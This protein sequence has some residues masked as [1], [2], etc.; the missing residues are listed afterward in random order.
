MRRSLWRLFAIR[1][2]RQWKSGGPSGDVDLPPSCEKKS[3]EL[4]V[5]KDNN[6]PL[7]VVQNVSGAVKEFVCTQHY[8]D[9]VADAEKNGNNDKIS[10]PHPEKVVKAMTEA[11]TRAQTYAKNLQKITQYVQSKQI[12]VSLP[13]P[14]I[15]SLEHTVQFVLSYGAGISPSWTL[16]AIKGPSSSG[17]VLAGSFAR[18]Q[19]LRLAMG[20]AEPATPASSEQA[21]IIQNQTILLSR[22]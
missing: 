21:R 12:S 14:P 16:V 7:S 19:I 2:H 11:A 9:D 10:Y 8:Y 4:C 5:F 18:T 15:D 1:R 6:D 17:P 20:P 22:P 3:T 13:D